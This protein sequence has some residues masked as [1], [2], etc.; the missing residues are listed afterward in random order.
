MATVGVKGL[1]FHDYK[2]PVQF[3]HTEQNQ[4]DKHRG[5]PANTDRQLAGKVQ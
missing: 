1:N 5:K 3:K 2:A 4:I